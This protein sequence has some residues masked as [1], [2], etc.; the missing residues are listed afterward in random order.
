MVS[1]DKMKEEILALEEHF[2]VSC[3]IVFQWLTL[4]KEKKN[5]VSV[6][7]VSL[8]VPLVTKWELLEKRKKK[9]KK[10]VESDVLGW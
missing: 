9:K 3:S 7:T 8:P 2:F 6:K 5:L 1:V 10:E 4:V